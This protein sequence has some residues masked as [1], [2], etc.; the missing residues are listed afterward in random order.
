MRARGWCTVTGD[1]L[2]EQREAIGWTVSELARRSG[3]AYRTI[4]RLEDAGLPPRQG[5]AERLA[6]AFDAA[7]P[8]ARQAPSAEL[9]AALRDQVRAMDRMLAQLESF[10]RGNEAAAAAV[11]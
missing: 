11:R 10:S 2:R 9:V 4:R 1:A 5:T 7:R 3:V 8:S 6:A